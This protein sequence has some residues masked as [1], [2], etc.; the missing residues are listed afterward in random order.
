MPRRKTSTPYSPSERYFLLTQQPLQSL[1]F[2]LPLV[3]LYEI[4]AFYYANEAIDRRL[5]ARSWIQEFLGLFGAFG[6]HLPGLAV[7]VVLVSLHVAQKQRWKLYPWLYPIM[8]VES[9]G[10]AIPLLLFSRLT[11]S[12]HAVALLAAAAD[13]APAADSWQAWMIFSI[14]AGIY[15]ELVFRMILI[16]AVHFVAADLLRLSFRNAGVV[17]IVVSAALF[18]LSHFHS[19]NPF[20]AAAFAFYFMA[21]FYFA[22]IY[23]LRGFGIVV[24]THA[25]YD[26]IVVAY[27][28][29]LLG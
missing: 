16:A 29:G 27:K 13:A 7:L 2:L 11:G 3:G 23:L 24:A 10:L 28:A 22:V 1:L 21:G 15:E 5:A 25:L 19:G 6:E 14:G 9:A 26:V 17:A 20:N 18:A 8:G 4:G 12:R